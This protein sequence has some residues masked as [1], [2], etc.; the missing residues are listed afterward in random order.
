MCLTCCLPVL[1]MFRNNLLFY[2]HFFSTNEGAG[3]QI[4]LKLNVKR[5]FLVY[6]LDVNIYGGNEHVIKEK[7]EYCQWLVRRLD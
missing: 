3:K 4:D 6:S 7:A 5:Q 2:R 1:G